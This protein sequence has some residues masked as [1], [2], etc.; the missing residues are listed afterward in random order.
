[1]VDLTCPDPVVVKSGKKEKK[2][3]EVM[4]IKVTQRLTYPEA[5]K[6][7]DQQTPEFTLS[8]IVS[9]APPKP[10]TIT[11]STQFN[12]SDFKIME[13]SKVIIARRKLYSSSQNV[14]TSSK[15]SS[16]KEIADKKTI[17]TE[18]KIA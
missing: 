9:S 5:R 8:K 18:C 2:E 16:E 11:T 17:T 12:E 13:S 15:S 1:M 7:Y 3:K 14:Q 4:K 10:E 6:V